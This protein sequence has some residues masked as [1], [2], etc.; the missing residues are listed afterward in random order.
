LHNL[1]NKDHSYIT[2]MLCQSNSDNISSAIV[3]LVAANSEGLRRHVPQIDQHVTEQLSINP[4]TP[5][6]ATWVQL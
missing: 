4:L 5:S 1:R 6:G 3:P 2:V